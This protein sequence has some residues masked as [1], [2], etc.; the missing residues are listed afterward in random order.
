MAFSVN[1]FRSQLTYDGARPNLFEIYM[2]FPAGVL[3]SASAATQMT[4]FAHAAS[5]PGSTIGNATMNYFGREIKV[6]G[7][8]VFTD[9]TVTIY[10]DEDF[11]VKNSIENWMN[12]INSHAGNI[13]DPSM[14]NALGYSVDPSVIQYGKT[15]NIIKQYDFVGLYPTDLG[16]IDLD[17]GANDTVEEYTVTFSYQYWTCTS[18]VPTTDS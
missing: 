17:W 11:L 4:F 18:P 15:G 2:T 12:L 9:W 1:D 5:L 14:L 16:T 8:R 10:N 7:N 13:R 6:P 3:N